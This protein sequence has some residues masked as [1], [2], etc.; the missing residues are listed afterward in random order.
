MKLTFGLFLLVLGITAS[1]QRVMKEY[2]DYYRTRIKSSVTY[3]NNGYKNGPAVYYYSNGIV[4]EK[5]A[6][7]SDTVNRQHKVD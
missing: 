3:D 4:G 2:Y 1:G 6:Y 5:G 7:K